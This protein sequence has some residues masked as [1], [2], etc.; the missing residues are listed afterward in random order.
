VGSRGGNC[1]S[2]SGADSWK[3]QNNNE[4]YDDMSFLH[5]RAPLADAVRADLQ[6]E[7]DRCLPMAVVRFRPGQFGYAPIRLPIAYHTI[8]ILIGMTLHAL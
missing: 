3:E 5:V 8:F 4:K 6:V 1:G 2:Y 7:L